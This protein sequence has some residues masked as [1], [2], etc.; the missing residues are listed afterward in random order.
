MI[1]PVTSETWGVTKV[2]GM[3]YLTLGD[4]FRYYNMEIGVDWTFQCR[5]IVSEKNAIDAIPLNST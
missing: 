1:T 5:E 4:T 2:E 3:L